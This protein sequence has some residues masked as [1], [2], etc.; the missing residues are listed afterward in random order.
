MNTKQF[1]KSEIIEAGIHLVVWLFYFTSINISWSDDW[2]SHQSQAIAPVPTII[3]PLFFYFNAFYLIPFFLKKRRWF[4]Y[5]FMLGLSCVGLEV[6]RVLI[7]VGFSDSGLPFIEAM[8]QEFETQDNLLIG[9]LTPLYS[10]LQF[11]FA[12]RFTRDWILNNDL[13]DKLK[14]E[15]LQMELSVL[16]AQINPHFLFNNLNALDDLIERDP[17]KAKT[18]L[19]KLSKMYRYTL[20]SMDHDVVMLQEEWDFIDDFIYL[21]S[22]RYGPAFHFDKRNELKSI[23]AYLIP[24]TSLQLL[25]ENVVKHNQGSLENPLHVDIVIAETG[26]TVSHEKR[27]KKGPVASTGK[28]LENIARRIRL[29]SDQEINVTNADKHFSV[30]LP[31]IKNVGA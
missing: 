17:A 30:T 29:L 26:I 7:Y 6:T 31:L 10:S 1:K 23:H 2:F 15:K 14:S 27:L 11:S 12:Y 8:A 4:K 18:Y 24:P 21:L 16:K 28:G 13:I 9:T 25:V 19:N 22:E 3:I 20:T 5:L